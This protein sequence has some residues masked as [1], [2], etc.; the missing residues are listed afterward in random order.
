MALTTECRTT[1]LPMELIFVQE[2]LKTLRED[3][4]LGKRTEEEVIQ[5]HRN[6]N[7]HLAEVMATLTTDCGILMR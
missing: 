1:G 3:I 5:L 7:P 2:C 4:L 6:I